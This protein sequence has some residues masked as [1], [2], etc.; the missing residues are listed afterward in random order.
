MGAPTN[1]SDRGAGEM[2]ATAQMHA[3]P[4]MRLNQLTRWYV[5][6]A[7]ALFALYLLDQLIVRG[8]T[9]APALYSGNVL[10]AGGVI[11]FFG[12]FS[13]KFLP[14]S[15]G[16]NPHVYSLGMAL[17]SYWFLVGGTVVWF[18]TNA[19]WY[20][21]SAAAVAGIPVDTLWVRL[22]SVTGPLLVLIGT[23]LLLLNVRKTMESRV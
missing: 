7:F 12:G 3:E 14:S 19:L 10:L 17:W 21:T 20:W 13:I 1:L 22:A 6:S 4:V 23:L 16:G 5:L 18:L 8:V 9:G 11:L 15:L 2:S